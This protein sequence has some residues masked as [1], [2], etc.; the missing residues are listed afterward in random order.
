MRFIF[1]LFSSVE[2]DDVVGEEIFFCSFI[3]LLRLAAFEGVF[4]EKLEL[5]FLKIFA[6]TKGNKLQ[7]R[8]AKVSGLFDVEERRLQAFFFY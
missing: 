6:Q 1:P 7:Y 2:A 5:T 3:F 8:R 4:A